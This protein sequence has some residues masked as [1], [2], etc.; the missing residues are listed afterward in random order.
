MLSKEKRITERKEFDRFFGF[1]FKKKYGKS[2]AGAYFIIKGMRN[3][4]KTS[5]F[6]FIVNNKIDNRATVRNKIKRRLREIVRLNFAK[7]KDNIDFLIV[8]KPAVKDRTKADL[9]REFFLL[10]GKL[11]ALK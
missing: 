5:R 11:G 3:E 2:L 9:E 7:I 8:V 6:G 1:T 4:H 10:M